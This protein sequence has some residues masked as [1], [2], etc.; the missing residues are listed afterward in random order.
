MEPGDDRAER[1][2][3]NRE[4]KRLESIQLDQAVE[5]LGQL[6]FRGQSSDDSIQAESLDAARGLG[7]FP[8]ANRGKVFDAYA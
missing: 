3:S 8:A 7:F 6:I 4:Q 2:A 1:V 5:R